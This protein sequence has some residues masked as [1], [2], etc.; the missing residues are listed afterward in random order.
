MTMFSIKSGIRVIII[1]MLLSSFAVSAEDGYKLWLRYD[2]ISNKSKRDEYQNLVKAL[3]VENN[4]PTLTVAKK[5]LTQAWL[6]LT[7]SSLIT[8]SVLKKGSIV[9]ITSSSPFEK[10][11]VWKAK[12][13]RRGKEGYRIETAIVDGKRCV[14]IAANEDIGVLYGTYHFIRLLQTQQSLA[15]VNI[16]NK[17]KIKNR[18]L[19]HWDNLDGTIERGY[20]GFSL[21]NWH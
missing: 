15:A 17:P 1:L 3:V 5:E 14:V 10:T 21:W 6:G 18:I 16:E 9:F 11:R 8:E 13:P 12:L 19:N 2:L 20:A 4:S 7:G